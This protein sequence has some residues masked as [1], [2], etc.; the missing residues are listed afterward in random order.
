M[1]PTG[2][3]PLWLSMAKSRRCTTGIL[4]LEIGEARAQRDPLAHAALSSEC[5]SNPWVAPEE[6]PGTP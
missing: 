3:G 1:E 5:A 2:E 4:E 6:I